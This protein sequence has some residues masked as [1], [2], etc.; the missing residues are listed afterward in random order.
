MGRR[1]EAHGDGLA[2][3]GRKAAAGDNANG[4][5]GGVEDFGP[6]AGWGAFHDQADANTRGTVLAFS[7]NAT[8]T[9]KIGRLTATLGDG[10]A[11]DCFDGRD[12]FVELMAIEG[13][14]GLEPQTVA[15]AEANR[16][17]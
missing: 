12:G 13:Q 8:G 5:A 9:G 16:L 3:R 7:E 15:S 6:F 10:K 11:Q 4:R 2:Q 14:A 17:D 1:H